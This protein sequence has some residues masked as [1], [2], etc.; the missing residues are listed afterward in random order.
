MSDK[1]SIGWAPVAIGSVVLLLIATFVAASIGML[2]GIP[3]GIDFT[4]KPLKTTRNDDGS[5]SAEVEVLKHDDWSWDE[6]DAEGEIVSPKQK[7]AEVRLVSELPSD[8]VPERFVLKFQIDEIDG[9]V[10]SVGLRVK[11]RVNAS[12][13]GGLSGGSRS[14]SELFTLEP[15]HNGSMEADKPGTIEGG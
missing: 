13:H 9:D 4:F 10:E 14:V 6:L 3:G 15:S 12:K 1:K 5:Y 8:P 2:S 7:D 11:L